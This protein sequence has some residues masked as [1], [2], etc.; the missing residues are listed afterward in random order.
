MQDRLFAFATAYRK[1]AERLAKPRG[2]RR[3]AAPLYSDPLAFP[4]LPKP[5]QPAPVGGD[6][7]GKPQQPAPPVL[8]PGTPPQQPG[9]R[10]TVTQTTTRRVTPPAGTLSNNP[11]PDFDFGHQL[12]LGKMPEVPPVGHAAPRAPRRRGPAPPT[13]DWVEQ[14]QTL[15]G[16]LGFRTG[17]D[18][19]WGPGSD[20]SLA[21]ARKK[22][23]TP[24]V[25]G[26]NWRRSDQR[27]L[28]A[29]AEANV[30]MLRHLLAG[31]PKAKAKA[32]APPVDGQTV[33]QTFPEILEQAAFD[34][35]FEEWPPSYPATTPL[36][37]KLLSLYH[38]TRKPPKR[39]G[40]DISRDYAIYALEEELGM[41]DAEE[42]IKNMVARGPASWE[43]KNPGKKARP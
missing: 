7:F 25:T 8:P 28:N 41:G 4:L 16:Q 31:S 24:L 21:A 14:M 43:E 23:G 38:R 11:M 1:A 10:R 5:G 3:G 42:R 9:S 36:H 15:L 40:H 37:K 39:A 19:K 27:K 35:G 18:G 34:L 20:R 17:V 22:H 26:H 32:P 12:Q 29:D 30:H 13:S 2:F 33:G 6:L